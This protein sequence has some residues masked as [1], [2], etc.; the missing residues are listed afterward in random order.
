V[1][2]HG[3]LS[4][5][6]QSTTERTGSAPEA[7]QEGYSRQGEARSARPCSPNPHAAE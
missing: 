7:P 2:V 6:A 1:P 4:E 3:A 5:A